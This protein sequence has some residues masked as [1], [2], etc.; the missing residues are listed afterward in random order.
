MKTSAYVLAL[1][2]ADASANWNSAST[3]KISI[4]QNKVD[5]VAQKV[6]TLINDV[7]N[8]TKTYEKEKKALDQAF[9]A[10][11]MTNWTKNTKKV[12]DDY[13]SAFNNFRNNLNFT[14]NGD[15]A[16]IKVNN[17]D[18]VV[19]TFKKANYQDLQNRDSQIM[20]VAKY[21]RANK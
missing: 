15:W 2:V 1:L 10:N 12:E 19:K 13:V 14:Q 11:V 17:D 5:D 9:V 4:D 8:D 7:L 18:S 20:D 21:V 3:Q 6:G 16:T